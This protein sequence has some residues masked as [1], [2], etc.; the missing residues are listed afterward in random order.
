MQ[1]MIDIG[2]NMMGSM[3]LGITRGSYLPQYALATAGTS[4]IETARNFNNYGPLSINLS[5]DRS[6]LAALLDELNLA[7]AGL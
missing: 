1:V 6:S 2:E 7:S 4:M 5:G 3:A